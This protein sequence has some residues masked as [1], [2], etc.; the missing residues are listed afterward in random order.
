MVKLETSMENTAAVRGAVDQLL[1]GNVGPLLDL[2]ADEVELEVAVGE[3]VTGNHADSGRAAVADYFTGLGGLP[4]FWQMDYTA[5]GEQVI[6]WGTERFT[7]DGCGLEGACEFALVFEIDD[8]AIT[9][10]LVVEDLRAFVRAT[11]SRP[12][13]RLPVDVG[14]PP[15]RLGPVYRRRHLAIG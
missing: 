11:A 6:A 8:G 2:V 13:A 4:A 5:A 7:I 14:D 12:A 1:A 9:R 3:D 15:R 10:L